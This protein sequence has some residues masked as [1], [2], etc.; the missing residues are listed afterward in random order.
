MI[1]LLPA[2][3]LAPVLTAQMRGGFGRPVHAGPGFISGATRNHP[4]GARGFYLGDTPYFYAD[5]PFQGFAA[6]P[7]SPQVIV[8]Q[9]PADAPQETKPGPLLIELRGDKYVRFG[10]EQKSGEREIT[11]PPDYAE[12]S[13]KSSAAGF[14]A[15]ARPQTQPDLPPA[16]LIYRDGHR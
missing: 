4:L 7:A 1:A 12:A 6:E 3:V 15:H 16:V 2:V 9:S 8:V 5:Y 11:V 10:G 14:T 13:T